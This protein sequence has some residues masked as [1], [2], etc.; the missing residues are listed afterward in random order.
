MSQHDLASLSARGVGHQNSLSPVICI[1][2]DYWRGSFQGSP[3]WSV[4]RMTLS[5]YLVHLKFEWPLLCCIP[6]GCNLFGAVD[7]HYGTS[8]WIKLIAGISIF[9]LLEE[10][11]G[12]GFLTVCLF[13]CWT[14][15][16]RS[17]SPVTMKS[18][19][20][21]GLAGTTSSK[22]FCRATKLWR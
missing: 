11:V 22:D 13:L 20:S 4:R 9:V 15:R 16:S 7:S 17:L 3:F 6:F 19:L 8:S 21:K 5:L 1:L 18:L 2:R 10:S 12:L 14:L